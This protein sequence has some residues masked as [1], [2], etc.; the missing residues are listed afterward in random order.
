M[1][2]LA[3]PKLSLRIFCAFLSIAGQFFSC[4]TASQN[5]ADSTWRGDTERRA[6]T[7]LPNLVVVVNTG[8]GVI[9]H[10]R[11]RHLVAPP[12]ASSN[13]PLWDKRAKCVV[14]LLSKLHQPPL[15]LRLATLSNSVIVDMHGRLGLLLTDKCAGTKGKAIGM[16]KR[17]A[18]YKAR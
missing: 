6:A 10:S 13:F 15:S 17:C 14:K 8:S 9:E 16:T 3:G 5:L 2:Y 7:V 12:P 18:R 1:P 4:Y 11:R